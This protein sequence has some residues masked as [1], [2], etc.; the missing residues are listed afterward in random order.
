[1][2]INV[3]LLVGSLLAGLV[4]REFGYGVAFAMAGIGKLFALV[5]YG[6]GRRWIR[7]RRRQQDMQT[8]FGAWWSQPARW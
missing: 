8:R 7:T 5:T 6:V 3:G 1:M 2:G 4:A